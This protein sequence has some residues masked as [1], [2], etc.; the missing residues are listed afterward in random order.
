MLRQIHSLPGLVVGLLLALIA[1]TGAILAIEPARERLSAPVVQA[2]SIDVATLAGR[3]QAQYAEI[4]RI[5]QTA[6]GSIVVTFFDG[7]KAGA[8]IVDPQSLKVLGPHAPAGFTRFVTNLHRSVLMG[9]QGR[10]A[11]GIGAALMLLLTISGMM[12]LAARLGGY[13][14]F[15]RPV[16]GS[17]AR[18]WHSELGRLAMIGLL[19]TSLSG[20]YLS[21]ATFEI[22]PDGSSQ[23]APSASGMGGTRRP[24]QE[25]DALKGIDLKD[26]RELVFPY[27]TDLTDTYT[28]TTGEGITQI[29]AATGQVLGF[30]PH[31]L[32]R[33][34]H[35][36]IYM[37]HTGQGLWPLA[38][39]LGLCALAVPFFVLTG[40]LIW[41]KR[42]RLS[43]N[44]TGNASART[45]ETILLVGSEGNSTWGFAATLHAALVKAGQSVHAAPMNALANHYPHAR[46]IIILTATYGDGDAPASAK[47][48]LLRLEHFSQP[49]PV[50]VLGFGDRAFPKFCRYAEAVSEALAARGFPELVGLHRIDRQSAQDFAQWGDE[51]GK[52]M[53]LELDVHHVAQRPATQQLTLERRTDYG[54][55]VQA[56]TAILRFIPQQNPARS[57]IMRL[58]PRPHLPAFEAGDLVGILPPGSDVPRFYSLASSSGDGFLELCVRKQ[59]GGLCSSFLHDL[60]PGEG[61]TMF[62]RPNPAFRPSRGKTPLILVGAGAGIAPLM[63]FIRRNAGH[64]PIHLYWGGRSPNADFLYKEDLTQ[65]QQDQRLASLHAVFSRISGGRYVQSELLADK[66]PIAGMLSQGAQ[67]MVC[68]GRE[69]GREVARTF[70]SILET[71]GSSLADLKQEGRYCEDIY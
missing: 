20:I 15:F 71:M 9:D 57:G 14:A 64:R 23:S 35:E 21:L 41:W 47:G 1:L 58:F 19:I 66:A 62:I 22:L 30:E 59:P 8:D 31:G 65:C 42:Q 56:A 68:G 37:L 63:G 17:S 13:R 16:Q 18:K 45:A 28:L 11:V 34:I 55:D 24:V 38:L 29:D 39:L 5:R 70:E 44:I 32:A 54:A 33:R 46:R 2:G 53:G 48:F 69:M 4:E 60:K 3:I 51:L 36:I 43:V 10:I 50:A 25:M 27:S 67:I 40:G 7:G 61:I 6:S 26:M 52:S 12:M 49:L